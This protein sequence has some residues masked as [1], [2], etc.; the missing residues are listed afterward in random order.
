MVTETMVS[1]LISSLARPSLISG[2]QLGGNHPPFVASF[3]LG[4]D[5]RDI[6]REK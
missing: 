4:A 3:K 1:S 6:K 5:Q 2:P